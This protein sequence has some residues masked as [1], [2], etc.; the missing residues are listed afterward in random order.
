[1]WEDAFFVHL[2]HSD[3]LKIDSLG[4]SSK[5]VRPDAQSKES[6]RMEQNYASDVTWV[7]LG[8][9][10]PLQ[11]VLGNYVDWRPREQ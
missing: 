11:I 8:R 9:R 6:A 1:M 5:V 4:F 2:A 7:F 3:W 10:R